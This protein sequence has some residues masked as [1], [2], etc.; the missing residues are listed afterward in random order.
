MIARTLLLCCLIGLTAWQL[1]RSDALEAAQKAE[2]RGE[3]AKSVGLALDHLA[4][5]PWSRDAARLAALGLSRI[6]RAEAAEPYYL[7]AGRLEVEDLQI[8]ALGLHRANLRDLALAAYREILARDPANITAMRR[9]AALLLA[10]NQID[11]IKELAAQLVAS[12][13]NA[14]V[15]I[16]RTLE[17]VVYHND[18]IPERSVEA[19]MQVLEVD[20][21]LR[22]MPLPKWL[23]WTDLAK[24]LISLGRFAE[25]RKV[26]KPAVE[27]MSEPLPTYYLG[28]ACRLDGDAEEAERW[29]R[30]VVAINPN[31]VEGMLA[32]GRLA[33]MRDQV[34]ESIRLFEQALSVE[35]RRIDTLYALAQVYRRTGRMREA[36]AMRER[37]ESLRR[38]SPSTSG[39]MGAAP[40]STSNSTPVSAATEDTPSSRVTPNSQPPR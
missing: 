32:L 25:A 34:D 6:D 19:W 40:R 30:R 33:L 2:R 5:R 12:H 27:G 8:R 13:S 14:G 37:A 10:M 36:E 24:D 39:G 11:D 38:R 15:S 16:G 31:Q 26:L 9:L 1:T 29:F 22:S 17:G 18:D 23:F 3:I 20:P 35:P 7:R 28:E 4:K 21:D